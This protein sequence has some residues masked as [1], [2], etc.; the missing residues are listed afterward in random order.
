MYLIRAL[1]LKYPILFCAGIDPLQLGF[2]CVVL[3]HSQ[4]GRNDPRNQ[5]LKYHCRPLQEKTSLLET[6][7]LLW[8]RHSSITARSGKTLRLKML[9]FQLILA[10]VN[11]T[12]VSAAHITAGRSNIWSLTRDIIEY[13]RMKVISRK[14]YRL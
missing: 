13:I 8:F 10:L 1:I 11:I 12:F 6:N 4:S 2:A 14:K 3:G 7:V 9:A 5:I